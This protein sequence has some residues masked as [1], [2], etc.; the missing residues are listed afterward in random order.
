MRITANK[1]EQIYT[2]LKGIETGDPKAVNC[3]FRHPELPEHKFRI[4][5][6]QAN[7]E[8]V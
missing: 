2:L 5:W 3:L 8:G 1:K 7:H 6:E 4:I